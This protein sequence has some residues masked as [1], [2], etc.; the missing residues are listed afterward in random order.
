VFLLGARNLLLNRTLPPAGMFECLHF[1]LANTKL[2]T[3]LKVWA[4][5][6]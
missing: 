2:L 1:F 3:G 5:T 4:N 6:R